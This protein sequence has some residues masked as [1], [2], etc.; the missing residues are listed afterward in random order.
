M[1]PNLTRRP[2]PLDK[3]SRPFFTLRASVPNQNQFKATL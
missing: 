3:F 2:F 1:K